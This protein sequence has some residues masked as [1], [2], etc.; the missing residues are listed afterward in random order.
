METNKKLCLEKQ[1]SKVVLEKAAMSF[2]EKYFLLKIPPKKKKI[3]LK[4][5]EFFPKPFLL[6]LDLWTTTETA[7]QIF[8]L[9]SLK[10]PEMGLALPS[11]KT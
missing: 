8:I 1:K 5:K 9:K 3:F 7:L 10:D 11:W 4:N 2:L 6:N